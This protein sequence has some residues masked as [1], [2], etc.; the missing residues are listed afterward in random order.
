MFR[1]MPFILLALMIFVGVAHPWIPLEVQSVLYGVSL[2]L[3]SLIVFSLPLIIF[4]L[5]F[6]T[7]V[8]LAQRRRK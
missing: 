7:A 5:L 6:K 4:G 3:K 1:K 8:G 2:S